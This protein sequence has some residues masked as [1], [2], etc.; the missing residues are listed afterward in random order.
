MPALPLTGKACRGSREGQ[1]TKDANKDS[2]LEGKYREEG[3]KEEK[4]NLDVLGGWTAL[5]KKSILMIATWPEAKAL[6]ATKQM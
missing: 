3:R 5:K 2:S 1:H 6:D 4:T